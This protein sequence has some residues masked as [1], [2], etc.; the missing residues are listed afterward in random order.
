V[1][2]SQIVHVHTREYTAPP[3]R[4]VCSATSVAAVANARA[5]SALH[6][7]WSHAIVSTVS[8]QPLPSAQAARRP[9]WYSKTSRFT[10]FCHRL[11]A[12]AAGPASLYPSTPPP[13]HCSLP[14]PYNVGQRYAPVADCRRRTQQCRIIRAQTETN[15]DRLPDSGQHCL[16]VQLC[17]PQIPSAWHAIDLI[18]VDRDEVDRLRK[19]FMKLDKVRRRQVWMRRF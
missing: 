6:F 9:L 7:V 5:P 13:F 19:R 1:L 17:V 14:P 15:G 12:S 2:I 8:P 3:I 4:S 11:L 16:R 10:L 18:T